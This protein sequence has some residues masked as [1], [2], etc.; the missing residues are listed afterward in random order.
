MPPPAAPIAAAAR[1][2]LRTSRSAISSSVMPGK[3]WRS[4]SRDRIGRCGTT[5]PTASATQRIAAFGL[6]VSETPRLRSWPA[7]RPRS[8]RRSL[9]SRSDSASRAMDPAIAAASGVVATSWATRPGAGPAPSAGQFAGVGV[10][11]GAVAGGGVRRGVCGSMSGVSAVGMEE[12]V[13]GRE[14]DTGVVSSSGCIAAASS[15]LVRLAAAAAAAHSASW[16]IVRSTS[17]AGVG[18]V[19]SPG[20][21]V[22]NRTTA[23]LARRIC[24]AHS[25]QMSSPFFST[26]SWLR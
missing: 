9:A 10:A 4:V 2:A 22:V 14:P 23:M 6:N 13:S 26:A 17:P 8:R 15:S 24:Q 11:P 5:S 18:L 7:R 20:A 16:L 1:A 19:T 12:P 25:L 21:D 3:C